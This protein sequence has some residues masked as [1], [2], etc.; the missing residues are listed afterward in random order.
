MASK[1]FSILTIQ[2]FPIKGLSP[3][4]LNNVELMS[5]N[6]IPGDRLYGF[7]RF[8]SGFDA[9]D[10]KPLPKSK[11]I[12]LL[13][14]AALAGLTTTFDPKSGL[15]EIKSST[16]HEQFTM[17]DLLERN[18]AGQFLYDFLKLKD[19]EAPTFVSAE[20]HRFTD[21]SVVSPVMMNAISI[22]NLNTIK[23]LEQRINKPIDPARFR[24]NLLIEGLPAWSELD[25][26]GAELV[27]G[28]VT[29]RILSR[30]QR[31]PATEVNPETT[32]RDIKL[33]AVL[34]KE[35]GHRDLGVYA[36]VISNGRLS[37]GQ[38]G[39]IK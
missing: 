29:L 10:P 34:K 38:K 28:D 23:D 7:A 33:P 4:P 18:R 37:L 31:C 3:E 22:V 16:Y 15:L 24:A 8:N 17:N 39:Y 27:L 12:V 20:P 13:N 6:G 36:E 32:E 5:G 35:M 2:R 21:V 11:F 26:I 14:Q 1:S 9:N 19:P 30:T 25:S